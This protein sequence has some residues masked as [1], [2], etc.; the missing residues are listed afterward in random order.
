MSD[1]RTVPTAEVIP[2]V[3]NGISAIA[4][5]TA[6]FI[7]FDGVPFYGLSNGVGSVTLSVTRQI[8]SGPDNSVV[9]DHVLVAHLRGNLIAIRAL[10]AALD[11]I[12]LMSEPAPE[13]KAN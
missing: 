8:A 2:S 12:L 4:S 5:A 10:R 9:S 13:G 6:P 11:G 3:G 7:Y 1:K